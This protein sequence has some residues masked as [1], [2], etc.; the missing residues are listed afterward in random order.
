MTTPL[1][2]PFESDEYKQA[3]AEYEFTLAYRD[4]IN[5]TVL[6]PALQAYNTAVEMVRLAGERQM[7]VYREQH[8]LAY[9]PSEES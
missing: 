2:D 4:E 9:G 5:E 6:K 8:R 3:T 7:R 1:F